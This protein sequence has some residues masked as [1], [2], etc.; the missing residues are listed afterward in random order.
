MASPSMLHLDLSG[1]Y[2]NEC[3][4]HLNKHLLHLLQVFN[5]RTPGH[6]TCINAIVQFL[7]HS[8]QQV[9]VEP[10]T[11]GLRNGSA[12][13]KPAKLTTLLTERVILA[14]SS[15]TS[16]SKGTKTWVFERQIFQIT[17]DNKDMCCQ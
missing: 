3:D 10:A 6:T 4:L 5:V 11:L 17:Q 1:N 7:P 13:S 14:C 2:T 12:T 16:R 15:A 8:T 9:G